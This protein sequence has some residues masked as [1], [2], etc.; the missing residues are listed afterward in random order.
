MHLVV[1]FQHILSFQYVTDVVEL[2]KIVYLFTLVRLVGPY[3]LL[4]LLFLGDWQSGVV[5]L[6]IPQLLCFVLIQS[7]VLVVFGVEGVA[8][9]VLVSE[10]FDEGVVQQGAVGSL[11]FSQGL[12][13]FLV[14]GGQSGHQFGCHVLRPAFRNH[15]AILVELEV[16]GGQVLGHGLGLGFVA[17]GLS[18]GGTGVGQ[19]GFFHFLDQL[20]DLV[21]Q[22]VVY[23]GQFGE[24]GLLVEEGFQDGVM[25][26]GTALHFQ[27][28]VEQQVDAVG[29]QQVVLR[30]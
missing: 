6:F 13:V 15:L 23:G 17:L 26:D 2:L 22:F 16:F 12:L 27:K 11:L 3:L 29:Q 24:K 19:R 21:L 5:V 1:F 14:L 20:V 25:G 8:V 30:V 7:G 28:G 18:D 10:G 9:G 4:D